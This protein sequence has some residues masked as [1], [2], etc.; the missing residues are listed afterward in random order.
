MREYQIRN[1][2]KGTV[3][4]V[5]DVSIPD[6]AASDSLNFLTLGDHVEMRRGSNYFGADAGV[7]S[8]L[9]LW[10]A[11]KADGTQIMYRK[12]GKKLEYYS[13]TTSLW[14]EVGT[15]LLNETDEASFANYDSLS[16]AQLWICSPNSGLYK[17]MTANPGS[18]TSQYKAAS[19]FKGYI[20]IYQS[21]MFLWNRNEDK[22]GVYGSC[23]DKGSYTTIT[24]EATASLGG[25][26]AF[27]AGDANRTCFGVTITLTVSGEVYTDNFNGVL[28]GSLG[29]TGTINYTSGVYTLS[30]AGVGTVA[31]QW[32]DS[33]SSGIADFSHSATRTAAQGF[34]FRQDD[35]G[36]ALQNILIYNDT[37][38]CVHE[39]KTWTLSI[40]AD[41]LTATNIIYRERVGI[42]NW[43]CAVATGSGVFYIDISDNKPRFKLLTLDSNSAEVIPLDVTLNYNFEN[44]IFDKGVMIE[45]Q[46][47]I[48]FSCRSNDSTTNNTLFAFNKIWKTI[49][50]LDYFASSLAI[51]NGTLVC[52]DTTTGNVWTL[53]S[54]W[55][56]DE[57]SVNAFWIGGFSDLKIDN[58]KKY[59]TLVIQGLIAKNQTCGVYMDFDNSGWENMGTIDGNESYVDFGKQISIGATTIGSTTIGGGG[60]GAYAYNF[61]ANFRVRVPKFRVAKIKFVPESIGYV[62]ISGYN[63]HDILIYRNKS[64]QKYE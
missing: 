10:I 8:V 14:V 50:R 54:A 51:Y 55:D 13:T 38:F 5:E 63:F 3:N 41:D 16:G 37:E 42:P 62:S 58:L 48:L 46:D 19:N 28:T 6:G 4:A 25:T 49:D 26:L 15:D 32:E 40:S 2:N 52:G 43:Q 39:K 47:Y 61:E 20:K 44:Y 27:K 64:L 57:A 18:Y 24:G 56:D 23:I 7:G 36:G 21:R 30:N 33:T 11:H 17:I 35:G 34:V 31:Y 1:F 12:R 59:K 9:G 60:D 53:F 22:T 45:W 29:G